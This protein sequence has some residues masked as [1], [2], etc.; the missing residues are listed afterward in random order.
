LVGITT[1][2]TCTKQ[3]RVEGNYGGHRE[4]QR[5]QEREDTRGGQQALQED[6]AP[7]AGSHQL[8]LNSDLQGAQQAPPGAVSLLRHCG[9]VTVT[10]WC[11]SG[12]SGNDDFGRALF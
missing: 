2:S 10:V 8:G 11:A 1:A 5:E 4:K 9:S 3:W 6:V 7:C 12:G